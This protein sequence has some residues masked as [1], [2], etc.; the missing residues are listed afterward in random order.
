MSYYF[1]LKQHLNYT[2]NVVHLATIN[3]C[4]VRQAKLQDLRYVGNVD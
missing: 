2:A 3:L 1:I 4:L